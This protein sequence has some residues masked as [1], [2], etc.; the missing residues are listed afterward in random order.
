[1]LAT[2]TSKISNKLKLQYISKSGQSFTSPQH[3]PPEYETHLNQYALA[4]VGLHQR[5]GHPAGGVRSRAVHLGVVLSRKG[6]TPMSSPAPI[7][8]YDDLTASEPRIAL[9]EEEDAH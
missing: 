4:Q 8:V 5:L 7:G 2:H 9:R 3:N 1:M 6:P